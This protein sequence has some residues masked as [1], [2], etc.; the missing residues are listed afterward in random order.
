MPDIRVLHSA[1]DG[2]ALAGVRSGGTAYTDVSNARPGGP[3]RQERAHRVGAPE[4]LIE[5]IEEIGMVQVHTCV[6]VH[7][8][9]CGQPLGSPG[10]E[11]HYPTEDAA[12]DAAAAQ[13]WRVGPGGRLWCS[14]C[15]PVLTCGAE[16]HK[17]SGRRRLVTSDGQ[18]ASSEYRHCRRCCLDESRPA[19][20]LI[21]P[22]PERASAVVA[23][24]GAGVHAGRGGGESR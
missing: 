7:C 18:P 9:Q 16:G 21:D 23:L 10:F 11:V 20:W 24:A 2:E 1:V 13:G 19:R 5:A 6:S 15:G 17:F 3:N 8:A 14:A 4:S 12:M 22:H